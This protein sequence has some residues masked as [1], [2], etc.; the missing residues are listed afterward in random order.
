MILNGGT[1]HRNIQT[2]KRFYGLLDLLSIRYVGKYRPC[3]VSG[4][5]QAVELRLNIRDAGMPTIKIAAPVK[6]L[7]LPLSCIANSQGGHVDSVVA[8]L[9]HVL[10]HSTRV[11][12]RQRR[13]GV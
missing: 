9:V 10:F 5:K 2:P 8:S 1:G 13:N 3:T 7:T 12:R 4:P 6:S 11:A